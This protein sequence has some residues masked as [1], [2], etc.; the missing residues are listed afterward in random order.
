MLCMW[1]TSVARTVPA[2][3]AGTCC[4]VPHNMGRLQEQPADTR[5]FYDDDYYGG[6]GKNGGG[7]AD[8]ELTAEHGL[9]WA[10]LVVEALLPDPGSRILDIGCADGHLLRRLSRG[11]GRFG[12]E[13]NQA[14][15]ERAEASGVTIIGSDILDPTLEA[16][17]GRT[18]DAVTAI[19]TFEHVLDIKEALGN[20]LGTGKTVNVFEVPLISDTRD[21]TVVA[22]PTNTSSI[23]R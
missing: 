5:Q 12:I 13:V 17:Y 10:K 21:N 8:Y 15:A 22:P 1:K 18:F 9:L 11:Y 23:P 2:A 7:Y 4:S 16:R 6:N 19:A 20:S 14:A 3:M